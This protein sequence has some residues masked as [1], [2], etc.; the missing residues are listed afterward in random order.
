MQFMLMDSSI[1]LLNIMVSRVH[2]ESLEMTEEARRR[3][4]ERIILLPHVYGDQAGVEFQSH[5][6]F[7]GIHV[8]KT[9]EQFG[10]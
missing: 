10:S 1:A 3:S 5:A 6:S 4:A 9:V 2:R 7:S 8:T